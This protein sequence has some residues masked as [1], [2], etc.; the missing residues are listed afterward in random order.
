MTTH[1]AHQRGVW[2]RVTGYNIYTHTQTLKRGLG[3]HA[4]L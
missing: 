2:H 1:E 3:A 4:T